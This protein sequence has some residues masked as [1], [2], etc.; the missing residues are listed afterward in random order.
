MCAGKPRREMGG[1]TLCS[2]KFPALFTLGFRSGLYLLLPSF[3]LFLLPKELKPAFRTPSTT[4][5][6]PLFVTLSPRICLLRSETFLVHKSAVA[7]TLRCRG[8]SP[9]QLFP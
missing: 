3:H 9:D 6:F 4:P 7:Q 8:V 1:K 2:S 5:S